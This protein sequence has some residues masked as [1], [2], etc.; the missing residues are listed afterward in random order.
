MRFK[1]LIG[2]VVCAL[3]VAS[4][5][6]ARFLQVDPIGYEDQVNLY[7]YVD[8][9]PVNR[10][11]PSGKESANLTNEALKGMAE[12]AKEHPADPTAVKVMV[13]GV[14]GAVSCALGCELAAPSARYIVRQ[15]IKPNANTAEP[16]APSSSRQT[17]NYR[18]TFES[19]KT[20]DGKGSPRRAAQTARATAA[21]NNDP[22]VSTRYTPRENSREAF[23]HESRGIQERGGPKSDKNYNKIDSPGTRMRKEDGEL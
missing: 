12:D 6:Q 9:D 23:K 21:E 18:H 13:A 16:P 17:G 8:D 5:L 19:N 1:A 4:P 20:Y 7:A 11:D 14:V 15:I 22:H 10:S 2:W 3:L